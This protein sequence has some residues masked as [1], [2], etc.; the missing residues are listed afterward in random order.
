M[1]ASG[2]GGEG[3][4]PD[5]VGGAGGL[6]KAKV[7]VTPGETLRIYV[8]GEAGGQAGF[9]SGGYN[10]GGDGGAPDLR[11]GDFAGPA[12]VGSAGGGGGASD[13]R[14]GGKRNCGSHRRCGRRRGRRRLRWVLQRHQ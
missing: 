9:G 8:G 4:S 2:A 5:S 14:Q 3:T 11:S 10:G 6:V 12:Y 1:T 7:I 13:V